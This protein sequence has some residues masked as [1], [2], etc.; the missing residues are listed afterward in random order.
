MLRACKQTGLA[1]QLEC[2]RGGAP[3]QTATA[4]ADRAGAAGLEQDADGSRLFKL[5]LKKQAPG[6]SLKHEIARLLHIYP[7]TA[8]FHRARLMEVLGAAGTADLV[9]FAIQHGLSVE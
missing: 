9:R 2:S 5:R 1:A 4:S 8:E 6:R 3:A 7:R